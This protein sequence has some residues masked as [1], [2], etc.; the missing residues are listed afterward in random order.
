VNLLQTIA[1]AALLAAKH[2]PSGT[3][4]EHGGMLYG[5]PSDFGPVVE[6]VEPTP[7][8][9]PTSVTVVDRS[10]LGPDDVLLGTYHVH[11]CMEG[12]YHAY[13]S[14]TDVV[15]AILSGVPEFMLDECTGEVHEFDPHQD[16]VHDTGID[17]TICGPN[18][19]ALKR[20]LPS[21]RIIGNIHESEPLHSGPKGDKDC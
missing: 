2:S 16:R 9:S 20:H 10:Q 13:F 8:G 14:T 5:H 19:E 11:L 15:T 6:Y 7:G 18:G 3:T 17:G 21:G 4:N 12:Y 1:M